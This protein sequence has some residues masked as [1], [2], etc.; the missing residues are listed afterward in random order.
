[1]ADSVAGVVTVP[2]LLAYLKDHRQE[3]PVAKIAREAK[4]SRSAVH[5][6]VIKGAPP[7]MR[8]VEA[9]VKALGGRLLVEIGPGKN[10]LLD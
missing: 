1:M 7:T 9:I 6:V 4:L 2:Q 5:D 10:R 8:T 3:W